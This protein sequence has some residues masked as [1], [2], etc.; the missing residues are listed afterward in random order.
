LLFD[1]VSP[2][3]RIQTLVRARMMNVG[4]LISLPASTGRIRLSAS[5]SA[6]SRD[7]RAGLLALKYCTAQS[8]M[9]VRGLVGL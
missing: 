5:A 8:C 7:S 9:I 2:H 6:S 1:E 4:V 3:S